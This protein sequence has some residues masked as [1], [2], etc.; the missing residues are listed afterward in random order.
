MIYSSTFEDHVQSLQAFAKANSFW[1]QVNASLEQTMLSSMS[2]SLLLKGTNQMRHIN[3]LKSCPKPKSVCEVRNF[4]GLGN[5]LQGVIPNCPGICAPLNKLTSK[6]AE[7]IWTPE[8]QENFKRLRI[9]RIL[10][11]RTTSVS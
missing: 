8:C 7:F 6:N 10:T 5:F 4:F 11:E 1:Q 9:I 3:A 2:T